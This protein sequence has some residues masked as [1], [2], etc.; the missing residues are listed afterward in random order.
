MSLEHYIFT[1]QTAVDDCLILP[2]VFLE[3]DQIG[4][5][6]PIGQIDTGSLE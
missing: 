1:A 5:P 3:F 6:R 2:K 4:N